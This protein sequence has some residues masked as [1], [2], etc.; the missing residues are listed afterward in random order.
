MKPLTILLAVLLTTTSTIAQHAAMPAGM[1]HEEHLKQ[2]QKD[3]ALKKRGGEAMGFDQDAAD[4]HFIVEAGG[5]SIQVT[6]KSGADPAVLNEVR[7]HLR[8]IA[9]DFARGDFGK[10]FQTHNEVPPGVAEMKKAAS[11]ISYR[12][13]D[14]AQGGAVRITTTDGKAL[15]AIHDFLRYQI[16]EHQTGD[17]LRP[18][19]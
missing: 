4:H 6:M 16:A 15:A 1:S 9:E 3:E 19:P 2:L 14:I 5:G 11:A 7:A 13:E 17:P 10:P 18:K 12:Y 8:T